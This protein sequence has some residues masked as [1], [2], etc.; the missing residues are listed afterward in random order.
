[1]A[2]LINRSRAQPA[3]N[4]QKKPARIVQRK[5]NRRQ[6]LRSRYEDCEPENDAEQEQV[7]VSTD[8]Q[9]PAIEQ[10]FYDVEHKVIV[11]PVGTAVIELDQAN[12]DE[13][14]IADQGETEQYDPAGTVYTEE[15]PNL[16]YNQQQPDYYD[17]QPYAPVAPTYGYADHPYAQYP[18][19]YV[20]RYPHRGYFP[21]PPVYGP[22]QYYPEQPTVIIS[23]GGYD[24][25]VPQPQEPVSTTPLPCPPIDSEVIEPESPAEH[26]ETVST[27]KNGMFDIWLL[28]TTS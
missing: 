24:H 13:Q 14:P 5:Q 8:D 26:P 21:A 27:N 10:T 16:V 19:V 25:E 11:R 7:P 6:R 2:P 22:P 4:N 15:Q 18:P 20:D 28:F 23:D 1:M 9:R 17:Q 3:N 12:T